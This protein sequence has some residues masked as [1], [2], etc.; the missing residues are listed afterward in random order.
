MRGHLWVPSHLGKRENEKG[1]YMVQYKQALSQHPLKVWGRSFS[2]AAS[3]DPSTM[4][5]EV[6]SA[7]PAIMKDKYGVEMRAVEEE[8]V[9]GG[10]F[11]KS[12][13]PGVLFSFVGK[14]YAGW[15][16]GFKKTASIIDVNLIQFGSVSK[17][18][19]HQNQADAKGFS[20]GGLLHRAMA[21]TNAIEE[22][23][24]LYGVLMQ[25]VE[26]VIDSWAA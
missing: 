18:M 6:M 24:M 13:Q 12:S 11:S 15:L 14:E 17:A 1:N 10:L 16:L 5:E 20:I 8:I 4:V 25:T 23:T 21:D 9:T 19:Q 2:S 22:E 3:I 7:V 26:E